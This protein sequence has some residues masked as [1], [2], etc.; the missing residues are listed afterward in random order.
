LL[1]AAVCRAEGDEERPGQKL[2]RS[3]AACH[4]VTDPRIPEDNDWLELN[5]TT[6]CISGEQDTPEARA[7]LIGYLRAKE[8]IRPLLVD[9]Q[10]GSPAKLARGTIRVPATAG[11]AYLK[12]ERE[13]VRAG[14]PPKVRLRWQASEKGKTLVLPAGKYRVINYSFYRVDR[15]GRRWAASGTSAEGCLELTIGDREAVF[16]LRPEVRG[17]LGCTAVTGRYVLGFYMTNRFDTRMSV[18]RDGQLS[19]PRWIVKDPA[20]KRVAAGD[21]VPS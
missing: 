9:E 2:W 14:T 3:C 13:S 17:H 1:L 16:D 10:H 21:F 7:A 11:S 12:A 4:C 15:Q 8:T 19:N 18:A 20:D 6:S 5:K